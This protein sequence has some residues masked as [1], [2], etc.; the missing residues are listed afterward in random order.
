MSVYLRAEFQLTQIRVKNEAEWILTK[1]YKFCVKDDYLCASY[2]RFCSARKVA[3]EILPP[4]SDSD[5]NNLFYLG[6]IYT[7]WLAL[8]FKMILVL[9]VSK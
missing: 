4:V 9:I 5:E 3:S 1:K 8:S 6:T 2:S 7:E